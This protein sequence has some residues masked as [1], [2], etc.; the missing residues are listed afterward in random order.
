MSKPSDTAKAGPLRPVAELP[1]SLA[2]LPR[3][4]FVT[5]PAKS[6]AEAQQ[7]GVVFDIT[8]LDELVAV[9]QK[10]FQRSASDS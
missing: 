7:P 9:A 4:G 6:R 1:E 2:R 5:R 10:H 3:L 8:S